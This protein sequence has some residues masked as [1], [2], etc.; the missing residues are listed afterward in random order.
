MSAFNLQELIKYGG[1]V[2]VQFNK[3]QFSC[4]NIW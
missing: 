2:Y 4:P 3:R 1:R